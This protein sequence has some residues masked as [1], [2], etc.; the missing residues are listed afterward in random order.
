MDTPARTIERL[1]TLAAVGSAF[2]AGFLL[3]EASTCNDT[4]VAGSGNL[5]I[6]TACLEPVSVNIGR[7]LLGLAAILGILVTQAWFARSSNQRTWLSRIFDDRTEAE[8]RLDAE[9]ASDDVED[10]GEGWAKLEE[11][12]LASR[13]EEE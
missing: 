6:A 3:L 4:V 10:M 11:R 8:V 5:D 9:D 12:M 7:A 13:V 2:G 1:F